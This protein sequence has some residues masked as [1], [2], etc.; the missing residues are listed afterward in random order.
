MSSSSGRVARES[1]G[2]QTSQ[3][4][5]W[6]GGQPISQLMSYAL[7]NPSLI[8][9]AA[10]FVDPETLPAD[11]A[12]DAL[13]ALFQD[14]HAA[15]A[16]LQYGT[17]AGH[18]PLRELLLQRTREFDPSG[19]PIALPSWPQPRGSETRMS[20]TRGRETHASAG[21]QPSCRARWAGGQPISQ[22]MA[23]ALEDPSRISLAAGFVD[24]ET[25]P[26]DLARE[27]L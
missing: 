26:T 2:Y 22:L 11:M 17:T 19:P 12:R 15:R 10:G 8:S 1:A 7:E 23:Y 4:A 20:S 16:A 21:Y 3:R 9:L 13:A 14:P 18:P 6:A 24:P 25:L 5:R 27:A